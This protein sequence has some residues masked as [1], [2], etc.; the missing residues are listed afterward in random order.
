MYGSDTNHPFRFFGPKGQP[1]KVLVRCM[2]S[3][4]QKEPSS[5]KKTKDTGSQSQ[6]TPTFSKKRQSSFTETQGE[7]VRYLRHHDRCENTDD[8]VLL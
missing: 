1:L 3:K 7:R 2:A 4:E 6:L 5:E 8:Q